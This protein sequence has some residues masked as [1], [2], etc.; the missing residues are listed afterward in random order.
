MDVKELGEVIEK[1]FTDFKSDISKLEKQV[2]ESEQKA[3]DLSKLSEKLGDLESKISDMSEI[4]DGEK[5]IKIK[6][7]IAEAQKQ[8]N[9]LEARIVDQSISGK[10]K[11]KSVDQ[12]MAEYFGGE[13]FKQMVE[14]KKKGY[15]MPQDFGFDIK[16]VTLSGIT[17][18]GTDS[19]PFSLSAPLEPGVNKP[20]NNPTLFYDLISKGSTSKEYVPWVER[21][22]VT[23]G[24][25]ARGENT[26]FPES[27][28]TFVE[29]KIDVKKIAD[30]MVVTNESLEDIDYIM[31]ELMEVLQYNIPSIRDNAIFNG[32]GTGANML[33][34]TATDV[35]KTF[36]RPAG[37]D[38]ITTADNYDVL[39]AAI[40]QVMLGN[41]AGD[42]NSIGF[43]PS[44]IVINPVDLHNLK[45]LRDND[46]KFKYPDLFMPSPSIAGVPIR[47]TTRM[48]AGSFLVGDF[49]MAKYFARR[50]MTIRMWD[51]NG[52][53]PLFDR[54]TFTASERGAL[55]VKTHDK[56][57]FVKGTFA[58]GKD[59]LRAE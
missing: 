33:G 59:A 48:T 54:V 31:S 52:T 28:I 30:S 42:A 41:S 39:S 27:A 15:K 11:I 8:I 5:K 20:N 16:A 6:E 21:L 14:L 58:A 19:I 4:K 45:M 13:Q 57:A 55:R 10:N 46:N 40:L 26:Q 25:A 37:I 1:K 49:G 53:D 35:A 32:D 56:F 17:A 36:A 38:K 3:K 12:Q 23:R 44:A 51:Q 7:F 18:I 47:T 9:A 34:L 24:A 29:K 22:L 2:N 43:A 50:G